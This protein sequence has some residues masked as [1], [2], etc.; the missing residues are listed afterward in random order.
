MKANPTLHIVCFHNPYPPVYGGVID[1]YY[2]LKALHALGVKVHFH[3]FV[4]TKNPDVSALE[5]LTEAV[6]VYRRTAKIVKLFSVFPFSAV[7]R[8]CQKLYANLQAVEAPILCEGLQSS[9]VIHQHAFPNRQKLLRLHNIESNYYRGLAQS[10]TRFWKRWLY[11][12]ETKKY[13]HYQAV[14]AKFDRVF[15]LSH[16]EQHY[17]QTH[18]GNSVYLP[19]FHGNSHYTELPEFGDFAF[20]HGDLRL[21]DNRK[22]VAF[23]VEVF[24]EIPDYQLVIAS[25]NAENYVQKLIEVVPNC[26]FVLLRSQN[27]LNMLWSATQINVMLSFQESGT[28]LKTINS[29]SKS[30]H[31]LINSNMVDDP[32]IQALCHLANTKE[33]FVAAIQILRFEEFTTAIQDQRKAVFAH[34]LSDEKNA[35]LLLN[36]LAEV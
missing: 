14:I 23:L 21:A 12:R 18:F 22:A 26:T 9:F 25:S 15:A 17:V 35:Q 1:V 36:E 34:L 5:N 2:K 19:V 28:K 16:F 33:E 4:D 3:C 13:E 27:Q 6:Y 20:Y 29:L 7:S 11:Q 30:R 32:Q 24:K 10:E 31:C 8:Y